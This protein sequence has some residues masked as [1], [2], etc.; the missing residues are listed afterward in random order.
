MT[1][2]NTPATQAPVQS[3]PVTT[4]TTPDVAKD[5]FK[6]ATPAQEAPKQEAPKEQP[7]EEPKPKED[8]TAAKFAA[9]SRKEKQAR[10][11]RKKAEMLAKEAEE[12]LSKLKQL[13]SDPLSVLES[14]GIT[15]DKLTNM[16]LDRLEGKQPEK[17]PAKEIENKIDAKI[18]ELKQE[19]LHKE[20]EGIIN[21]F[22]EHINEFLD[23]NKDN[24]QLISTYGN[25]QDV[26]DVIDLHFAKTGKI[27][28]VKEAA[29]LVENYLEEQAMKLVQTAK[30]KAKLGLKDTSAA[31]TR[32]VNGSGENNSVTLTN[33]QA[34][35]VP[36]TANTEL[37]DEEARKLAIS[38]I[39]WD[40]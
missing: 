20:E 39:K 16:Q 17:D 13:E 34:T 12:K 7:K 33:S 15:Y 11:E 14:L 19:Q 21:G 4:L 9:L 8:M 26:Y 23:D 36:T 24:Y 18:A 10:E 31:S 22:K 35:A 32:P 30:L 1:D 2:T 37:S 27:L 6:E 5:L 29:D 3:E 25:T 38:L 28:E 40:D